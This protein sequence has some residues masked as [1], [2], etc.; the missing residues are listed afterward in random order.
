[1]RYF[2]VIFFA[3]NWANLF[4]QTTDATGKKQG[5]WKKNDAVTNKLIYEGEFKDDKPVGKFKYYYPH[6]TI[7]AILNFRKDGQTA[8]A[9]LFHLNG[10]RMAVGKYINKEIKDSVW[11]Y[12]DEEALLISKESYKNGKKDGLC[13]VYLPDGKLAEEI[14]YKNGLPEGPYKKYFDGVILREKGQNVKGYLDGKITHYFPNGI[15]VATG[16]YLNGKKNGV[17][18]Y[19]NQDGTLKERELHINGRLASKK[20]TEAFF[21]KNKTQPANQSTLTP[22]AINT[23][24]TNK[25][26]PKVK[27]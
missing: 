19:K 6:D 15:E 9:Q 25:V 7:R 8:S 23:T 12:Y 22:K 27:K 4:S 5:Y 16:Y 14:N 11:D 3:F 17:W 18:V 20:E 21:Q 24:T 10:K 13:I 1:M 2:L 26:N